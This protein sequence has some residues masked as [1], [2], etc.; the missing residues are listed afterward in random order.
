MYIE[1]LKV[2]LFSNTGILVSEKF[3]FFWTVSYTTFIRYLKFAMPCVSSVF[4]FKCNGLFNSWWFT[5]VLWQALQ[6]FESLMALTNLAQMNDEVRWGDEVKRAC[7]LYHYWTMWIYVQHTLTR[8]QKKAFSRI[9]LFQLTLPDQ[10]LKTRPKGSICRRR[11][12]LHVLNT[13]EI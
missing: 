10:S 3:R 2:S 5:F 9:Q 11:E 12:L 8:V 7:A 6:Q 1:F 13:N 4:Y